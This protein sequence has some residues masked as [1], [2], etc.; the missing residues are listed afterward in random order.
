[1]MAI[2]L[3]FQFIACQPYFIGINHNNVVA[4]IQVGRV[5]RL[6]LADQY[7]R[8][9][10]SYAAHDQSRGV[11]HEPPAALLDFFGLPSP[12]NIRAHVLSHTFPCRDK[13]K[14]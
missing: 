12:G 3:L 11:H 10:R 4:T 1:M 8:N 5:V 7:S 9:A 2:N 6:I 14:Q 13:R